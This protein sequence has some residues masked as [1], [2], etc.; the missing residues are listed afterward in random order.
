MVNLTITE[1]HWLIP[2][3]LNKM[4]DVIDLASISP[5]N[6]KELCRTS[7]GIYYVSKK[8]TNDMSCNKN[9]RDI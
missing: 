3:T 2:K 1:I 4:S 7:V 8:L 6:R 9:E 5:K